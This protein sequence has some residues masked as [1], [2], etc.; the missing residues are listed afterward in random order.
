MARKMRLGLGQF[1]ELSEER[2]EIHQ[3]TWGRRCATQHA[4]TSRHRAV[5]IHGHSSTPDRNRK[6]RTTVSGA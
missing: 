1:S 5:G 2:F 6:C 4:T 3:A